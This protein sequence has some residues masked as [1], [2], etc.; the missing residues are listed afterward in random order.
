VR[1]LAQRSAEAAKTTATL[2]EGAQENA[3]ASV[4]SSTEVA[5][6]LEGIVESV[7][8]ATNL[9]S[10]VTKASLEQKEGIEQITRAVAEVDKVVQSNAAVSDQSLSSSRRL[11]GETHELY[12]RIAALTGVV[13]GSRQDGMSE[14]RAAASEPP[15]HSVMLTQRRKTA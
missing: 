12:Q 10:D 4:T 1:N 15:L 7:Q 8:K 5:A 6:L 14:V 11:E 3:A 2:I 13:S 9:V